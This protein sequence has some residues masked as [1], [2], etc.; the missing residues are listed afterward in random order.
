MVFNTFIITNTIA[1]TTTIAISNITNIT[2]III[3]I[4]ITSTS[5]TPILFFITCTYHRV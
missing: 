2:F 4:I 1:T 5:T 3:K